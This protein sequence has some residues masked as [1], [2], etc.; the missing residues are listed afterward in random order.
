MDW[1]RLVSTCRCG[2]TRARVCHSDR[3]D[4]TRRQTWRSAPIVG[5]TWP[6]ERRGN[7]GWQCAQDGA[8]SAVVGTPFGIPG[9][10]PRGGPGAG[11]S[12][13]AGPI[14]KQCCV[15]AP[16]RFGSGPA[17]FPYFEFLCAAARGQGRCRLG[18]AGGFAP[19]CGLIERFLG[20][21]SAAAKA[22]DQPLRPN[23][24]PGWQRLG[25]WMLQPAVT[26]SR[27]DL[28]D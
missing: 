8:H 14:P 13:R 17:D 6:W 3:L 1:K 2:S 24:S 11:M 15:E 5:A 12:G 16:V 26:S 28:A 25:C 23:H 7:P 19:T 20:E 10:R 21:A 27:Q 4:P 18:T 22:H 9:R